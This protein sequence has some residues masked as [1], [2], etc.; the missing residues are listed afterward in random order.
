[1]VRVRLHID[2]P[3]NR[4]TLKA[5]L[6][7]EGHSIV[8]A[9]PDAVITDDSRE[10]IEQAESA[11]SLLITPAG[12]VREAVEAMR[13][14]VFGYILLPFQPGEAGIMVDRA[15]SFRR[16]CA[17]AMRVI[18]ASES[19]ETRADAERRLILETL[20]RCK[21]NRSRAARELGI[22]R[23]TLW[24]KLRKFESGNDA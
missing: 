12:R 1:M 9:E 15:V 10:A 4:M 19:A 17:G 16:M 18:P 2:D 7:A 11:A 22:G 3:V 23:N 24:R 5:M 14:G 21:N 6:E 13:K 20:R 8:D